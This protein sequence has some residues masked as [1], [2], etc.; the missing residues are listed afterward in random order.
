[1][2][3]GILVF[4]LLTVSMAATDATGGG[5]AGWPRTAAADSTISAETFRSKAAS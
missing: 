3:R 1:M 5:A 4:L 2:W